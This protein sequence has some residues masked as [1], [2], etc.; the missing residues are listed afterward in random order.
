ME[1]TLLV[2]DDEQD[3]RELITDMLV[4]EGF[5]CLSAGS[6]SEASDVIATHLEQCGKIDM[7][8]SDLNMPGGSGIDLLKDL[9]KKGVHTPFLFLSGDLIDAEL[10]PYLLMGVLGYQLKPFRATDF[11][12]RLNK[13]FADQLVEA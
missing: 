1:R 11:I 12:H 8:I 7:I 3:L 10:R 2:I 13:L 4:D 9:R 6:I 5:K